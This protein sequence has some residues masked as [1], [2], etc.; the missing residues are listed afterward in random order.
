MSN[1]R[2]ALEEKIID[3]IKALYRAN[4]DFGALRYVIYNLNCSDC[5]IIFCL[6]N[7]TRTLDDH[8]EKFVDEKFLIDLIRYGSVQSRIRVIKKA[9]RE[10]SIMI[11][12]ENK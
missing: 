9:L 10:I 2:R 12:E 11:E 6:Q 1:P 3:E 7:I 4:R 8:I 5:D